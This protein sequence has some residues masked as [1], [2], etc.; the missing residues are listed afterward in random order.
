[1][2]RARLTQ[3]RQ[4]MQRVE[5]R[6]SKDALLAEI[7]KERELHRKATRR[8]NGILEVPLGV[9]EVEGAMAKAFSVFLQRCLRKH[10]NEELKG[11]IEALEVR[12][13]PALEV[14]EEGERK[15]DA[16]LERLS[17]KLDAMSKELRALKGDGQS[18]TNAVD[19]LCLHLGASR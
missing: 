16:E 19:A 12:H 18:L 5:D 11:L 8:E 9:D 17:R 4:D 2:H 13:S 10:L 14:L 1:M 15:R 3:L 7:E 6:A